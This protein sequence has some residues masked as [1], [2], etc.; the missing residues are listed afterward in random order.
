[1][2]T[3]VGNLSKFFDGIENGTVGLTFLPVIELHDGVAHIYG[4]ECKLH[5]PQH[6]DVNLE[7]VFKLIEKN[8]LAH[9]VDQYFADLALEE[10]TSS[11]L[12]NA[13]KDAV[14]ITACID[15]FT[16]S[17]FLERLLQRSNALNFDLNRLVISV[18]ER[19]PSEKF[20]EQLKLIQH[21]AQYGIKF[22]GTLAGET[23]NR[24]ELMLRDE[25]PLMKIDSSL[26]Q[27]SCEHSR[28]EKYLHNF[29]DAA[30]NQ[31][32]TV[33]ACGVNNEHTFI[34]MRANGYQAFTGDF[35]S[36]ELTK[37]ELERLLHYWRNRPIHLSSRT[38]QS[39]ERGVLHFP[40]SDELG[41]N[42]Q[43][44]AWPKAG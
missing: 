15:S 35:F 11:A 34:S 19:Y 38:E 41:N 42:S 22:C 28:T 40:S 2:N 26:V 43:I 24:T 9:I 36:S 29:Y 8:G 32:K 17:A 10:I 30:M 27:R 39:V 31:Q 1:M 14:F 12:L 5:W 44:I 13:R 23:P 16:T 25:F 4:V 21:A 6:E 37:P 7:S 33:I 18:K 20:A 3:S